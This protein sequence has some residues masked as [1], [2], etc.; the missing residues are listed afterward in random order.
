MTSLGTVMEQIKH[1]ERFV[2]LCDRVMSLERQQETLLPERKVSL[3]HERM[4]LTEELHTVCVEHGYLEAALNGEE[5]LEEPLE[6]DQLREFIKTADLRKHLL[7][8]S[9]NKLNK[10]MEAIDREIASNAVELETLYPSLD[11][12]VALGFNPDTAKQ[13]LRALLAERER[14]RAAIRTEMS[15]LK[16]QKKK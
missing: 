10:Q 2:E 13:T 7:K 15:H 1:C 14:L 6:E 12:L 3:L 8:T 5:C 9:I 16:T 11:S 4:T